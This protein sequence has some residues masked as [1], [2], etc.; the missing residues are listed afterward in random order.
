MKLGISLVCSGLFV[1]QTYILLRNFYS[2]DTFRTVRELDVE[3]PM[4]S[5]L[6]IICQDPGSLNSSEDFIRM[7]PMSYSN[8]TMY[9][10]A[11]AFKVISWMTIRV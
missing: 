5:P 9:K 8:V 2:K 7:A 4:P 11:T 10:I 3:G 1:Y 6:F